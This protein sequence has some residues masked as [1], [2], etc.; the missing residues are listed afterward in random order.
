MFLNIRHVE[1]NRNKIHNFRNALYEQVFQYSD[2]PETEL[3]GNRF[4]RKKT[5]ATVINLHKQTTD[6][7]PTLGGWPFWQKSKQRVKLWSE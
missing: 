7:Q 2:S 4:P 6:H 3:L 5:C 1:C